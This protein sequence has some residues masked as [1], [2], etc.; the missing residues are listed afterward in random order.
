M[1]V[2]VPV[3]II[4]HNGLQGQQQA[5]FKSG[6]F[7]PMRRKFSPFVRENNNSKSKSIHCQFALDASISFSLADWRKSSYAR[8]VSILM[9]DSPEG[10]VVGSRDWF[11]SSLSNYTFCNIQAADNNNN[12]DNNNNYHHYH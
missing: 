2:F 10:E 9:F 1:C 8:T 12:S 6:T 4:K 11:T 5:N 7:K 3:I